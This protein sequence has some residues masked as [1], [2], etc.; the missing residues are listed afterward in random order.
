MRKHFL[1]LMLLTLLPL[2]SWAQVTLDPV[3]ATQ[4]YDGTKHNLPTIASVGGAAVDPANIVDLKWYRVVGTTETPIEAEAGVF[5]YTNAGTYKCTFKLNGAPDVTYTANWVVNKFNLK[6][7]A[8][9]FNV[10]DNTLPSY[11]QY[12]QLTYGDEAPEYTYSIKANELPAAFNTDA[13]KTAEIAAIKATGTVGFNCSYQ[14]GSP[15]IASPYYAITPIVTGEG[16]INSENYNFVPTAGQ[17]VVVAKALTDDETKFAITAT[18]REYNSHPQWGDVDI[19]D[20]AFT[21]AAQK[22]LVK[23]RDFTVAF[24]KDPACTATPFTGVAAKE[25]VCYTKAE[26]QAVYSAVNAMSAD[27]EIGADNAAAINTVKGSTWTATT[28]KSEVTNLTDYNTAVT[29]ITT[30]VSTYVKTAAVVEVKGNNYEADT[31]YMKVTGTGNYGGDAIVVPFQITQK[32][33]AITTLN[34]PATYNGENQ[35]LTYSAATVAFEG[36][37]ADDIAAG[38]PKAAAFADGV[39]L[40]VKTAK[41]VKD[42]YVAGKVGTESDYEIIAYAEKTVGGEKV[43]DPTKIFKNYQVAYFN[44]GKLTI[45]PAVLTFTLKDQTL[46]YGD[47]SNIL[48]GSTYKPVSTDAADYFTIT[49]F[50]DHTGLDQIDGDNYP[51]L[52]VAATETSEGSKKYAITVDWSTMAFSHPRTVGTSTVYDAVPV[53]NYAINPLPAPGTSKVTATLTLTNGY[54]SVRPV[55]KDIIYGAEQAELTVQVTASNAADKAKAEAVLA[56]AIVIAA[57][58]TTT[59][60]AYPNVGV[61]TMTLDFDKIKDD[62]DYIALKNN[63]DISKFTGTYTIAKRDLTKITVADQTIP[64]SGSITN[65]DEDLVTFEADGYT[66]SDYDKAILKEEFVYAIK[67]GVDV[68]AATTTP[69]DDA[70][71]IVA[72]AGFKNFN[73]PTGV[74]LDATHGEVAGKYVTGKLTVAAAAAAAIVLNPVDKATWDAVTGTDAQ[75][76]TARKAFGYTPI[77]NN[78]GKLAT[79]KFDNF[80]MQAEYWYT[81]VLPFNTTVAEISKELGYAVVNVLN[82]DNATD[83][84][85]FKL[86]M[87][88]IPANEP[89]LVKVYKNIDLGDE[90]MNGD[91]TDPIT[92]TGKSIVFAETPSVKDAAGNQFIGTFMGYQIASDVDDEYY[93]STSTASDNKWLGK[94]YQHGYTRPSGAYLKIVAGAG[95]R[96]F[97][98]EPDG[99]TTAIETINADGMAVPAEGWYTLNGVKLQAAPT[100]KGIYI[101]NGKKIVVK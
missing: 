57:T 76:E 71:R 100:Q 80:V 51:T 38:L 95:A 1:I 96:I 16:R 78:N 45:N 85:K 54:I 75:K 93:M 69:V 83:D 30:E 22:N 58:A 70:I 25:A 101:N 14:K 62:A 24:Y 91:N 92:F 15:V 94:W 86:W 79:V 98:E 33:L 90:N 82:K 56:K 2:A 87:Q 89:F 39:T 42:V 60:A 88:E 64:V 13:K 36:L 47:A 52:N 6:I 20:L 8:D 19:K 55:N 32:P 12:H 68:S 67:A 35:T 65:L 23:D 26:L 11:A 18:N 9:N 3:S 17:L 44:G 29:A 73:I 72:A 50:V 27:D 40:K 66:L 61:Y 5:K 63:Y 97:I 81:M 4:T 10:A 21:A 7:Y 59:G 37:E 46:P 53:T 48:P 34:N 31:Y 99:S 43:V 74:T 77:K 49:G 28:K 84:V 41:P